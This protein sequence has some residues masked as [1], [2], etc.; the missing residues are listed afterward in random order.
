MLK[1]LVWFGQQLGLVRTLVIDPHQLLYCPDQC[2]KFILAR[3]YRHA[4]G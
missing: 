4:R 1:R 2:D 3:E